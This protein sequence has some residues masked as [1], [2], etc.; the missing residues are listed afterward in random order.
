[1]SAPETPGAPA[2]ATDRERARR[3]ANIELRRF[4]AMHF[5]RLPIALAASVGAAYLIFRLPYPMGLVGAALL[6][7][8]FLLALRILRA[9]AWGVYI[10]YFVEIYRPQDQFGFLRAIKPSL[11]PLLLVGAIFALRFLTVRR[12]RIT[13]TSHST[14]FLFLMAVMAA[15]VLIAANTYTAYMR[16]QGMAL[17]FATYVFATNLIDSRQALSRFARLV[18]AL[19][20]VVAVRG[21]LGYLQRGSAAFLDVGGSYLGDENDFAMALLVA[22]PFGFFGMTMWRGRARRAAAGAAFVILLLAIV[23]TFSRGGA[24]ALAASLGFS[25]WKG[26]RRAAVLVSLLVILGL[27]LPLIPSSYWDEIRTIKDTNEGTA[28]TRR[29]YWTAGWRMFV[30][31]PILGVGLGNASWR[32]PEYYSGPSPGTRWGRALHGTYHQLLAELG[33]LGALAVLA[34]LVSTWRTVSRS[35]RPP[36]LT[37]EDALE[38]DYIA[39]SVRAGIVGYLV[40]ATFLSALEYP[41]LYV[42]ATFAALVHIHYHAGGEGMVG[43]PAGGA[44]R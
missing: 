17:L 21:L 8:G 4:Q 29:M 41:H 25:W 43:E 15:S 22:L 39:L 14:A 11:A 28:R 26:K 1:M 42:F 44:A 16:F 30:D 5:L 7:P 38:R 33:I 10:I 37:E 34:M 2:I 35:D 3:R 9:P 27:V 19:Y 32:L 23:L 13:W 24:V 6:L 18:L 20:V 12:R 36:G 40:A 31:H